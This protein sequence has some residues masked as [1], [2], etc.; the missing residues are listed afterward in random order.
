LGKDQITVQACLGLTLQFLAD[1]TEMSLEA[2]QLSESFRAKSCD[3]HWKVQ[4]KYFV[5]GAYWHDGSL[6]KKA[7]RD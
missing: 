1:F 5:H 4:T 2:R 3:E 6:C 7:R